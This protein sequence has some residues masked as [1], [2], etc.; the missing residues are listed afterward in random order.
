MS[1]LSKVRVFTVGTRD[2]KTSEETVCMCHHDVN[3]SFDCLKKLF[4]NKR[5][6]NPFIRVDNMDTR[7]YL[8]QNKGLSANEKINVLNE[9][10][11]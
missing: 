6:R 10:A 11:K 1:H 8:V 5:E 3:K 4:Q 9:A 7:R 2:S